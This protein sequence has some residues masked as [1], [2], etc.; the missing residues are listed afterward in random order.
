MRIKSRTNCRAAPEAEHRSRRRGRISLALAALATSG[1]LGGVA[2]A[3]PASASASFTM[4]LRP[5]NGFYTLLDLAGASTQPGAPVIAWWQD[6]GANQ[7]WIFQSLGFEV[8]GGNVYEI[9][10]QN[11]SQCLTTNGVAGDQLY[12][13]PCRFQARGHQVDAEQAWV[14]KLDPNEPGL[15]YSIQSYASLGLCVDVNGGS[16]F[17]GA[18]IDAYSCNGQ[19]NQAF[20]P[21]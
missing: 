1:L 18:A 16:P 20:Y 14:T 15:P 12:Q 11:S 3:A 4:G 9:I 10:N 2:L 8:D 7:K 5:T 13:S 6:G 17:A 19:G 21:A